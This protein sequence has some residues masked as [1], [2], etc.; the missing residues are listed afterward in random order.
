MPSSAGVY[1]IRASRLIEPRRIGGEDAMGILYVGRATRLRSRIWRFLDAQHTASGFLW[2]NPHIARLV[3]GSH[4]RSVRDV[5]SQLGKL[6]V[7][8]ATPIRGNSLAL[9]ERALLFAYIATFGEAPP[10]NLS[11]VKRWDS[12]PKL[13]DLRWAEEGILHP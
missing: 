9:A 13:A 10:L 4:I 5:E 6:K 1:I 8:Y 11:L 2:E 3:I 12:M 7:R